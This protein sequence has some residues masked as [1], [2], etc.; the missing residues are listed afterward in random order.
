MPRPR[1][2]LKLKPAFRIR[3]KGPVLLEKEV[4]M[5]EFGERPPYLLEY[6]EKIKKETGEEPLLVDKPTGEMKKWRFYSVIY[7]IGGGV[8]IHAYMPREGTETGYAKYIIIEPPR[9]PTK[10]FRLIEIAL[11]ARIQPY[12]VAESA[13]EKKKLLLIL[14]D[15][16]IEVVDE[17]VNYEELELKNNIVPV[18][19]DDIDYVKYHMI[20]DKIG[21]GI[22]EP[23]LRDP[24][25]EDIS[26]RGVGNIYIVHK[27]FG[28]MESNLGFKSEAELD[29]FIIKLGEK[30][31]KP[32]TH[33]R[34]VVDATL[35]DGSRIN[36][37]YGKDVSLHGS[38]FTI[39]RVAK[40][41]ISVTQLIKWGTF[42]E[43]I[44]AYMWMMLSEGMSVFICGET[45][46]GKTTS[47]NAISAFIRP[48]Y[49][50]VTIEDT[51]EV[52]LPHPNWVRELTRDTGKPESSVTMFDLLRAALRQRPNYIIV[53]EIRG[54][55]G[56]IAFQAMQSV[57]WD[58][59]VLIRNKKTGE[60]KLIRIGE[61]VDKFYREDEE[62][63]P[64]YI[65]GLQVLS[66]DKYG[67]IKWSDIRYVLRHKAPEIYVITYEGKGTLR[68]TG[69]HSVFILD[70]ETLEVRPKLV[71][72][73]K[74]GDILASFV[75]RKSFINNLKVIDTYELLS[76][77]GLKVKLLT[78]EQSIK[79]GTSKILPRK[80]IIDNDLAY[81]LG[82][83]L[84]DEC[85]EHKEN[86]NPNVAF[87]MGKNENTIKERVLRIAEKAGAGISIRDRKSYDIIRIYNAPLAYTV[88]SIIGSKLEDEHVP[89][90]LWGSP[91]PVIKEFFKGYMADARRTSIR[92]GIVVYTTKKKEL[93][94]QLVWLARL[95]GLESKMFTINDNRYGKYYD[96]HIRLFGKGKIRPWSD[97]IP[98]KP[99]IR[100]L[101]KNNLI[102]KLPLELTY[103]VKRWRENRQKYVLRKTARKLV[104]FIEKHIDKLD[105]ESIT[106]LERLKLIIDSD[107]S[108]LEV[109]DVHKEKYDGYVYD[110]SVPETELFIGGEIPVALHNTGHPVMATFHAANLERLIQRLTNLPINVPKTNMDSLNIAWFQSAVYSKT[111][112]LV[113]R[114][115]TVN[116]IV[117]YDPES[118]AISAIPVFTWDP[119]T[120]QFRFAGRGSSYLLEEKIAVM[121]GISRRDIKLIYEELDLRAKYLRL[122]VDRNIVDYFKVF[123]A[124]VKAYQ[125]GVEEA[126]K[127]L[128]RG[129]LML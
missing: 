66:M 86:R 111:G 103:I 7:P 78:E 81:F 113:R 91:S 5:S 75:R 74:K 67:R 87:S 47:L 105:E 27:I 93:A 129:D 121:K 104:E 60:T 99:I 128:L 96:V 41:P 82:A 106:L 14:L 63:V 18:Y 115:I 49:K 2:K 40:I 80:L 85:I 126:Y 46:S 127:K 73:L 54:A 37:V 21:V 71:S 77:Q 15:D 39:R 9:P 123:K 56:N 125:L 57:S 110:L 50:I 83:Y 100:I 116:E 88:R 1:F 89:S 119:A 55:E 13:E 51:A 32:I 92:G 94:I 98:L 61:F 43:Y 8:F 112:L 117:G 42:N 20:R 102:S 45:A 68:A 59:P 28:S 25:I 34:P 109:L 70:P 26:C 114:V 10:L 30:I 22:L 84:A 76:K 69:S 53:G 19:K 23:F 95:A 29:E 108:F 52:V 120:D 44:A 101:E 79:I 33:A 97:R 118:D 11:A 6:I 35:P 124:I 65:E 122:L 90:V 36:I 72:E 12:H 62:R 4:K 64:K 48:N 3:K 17:P 58:T 16:V 107:L 24:Y 31:G 38:N